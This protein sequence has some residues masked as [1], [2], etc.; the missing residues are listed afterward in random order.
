MYQLVFYVPN[1]H[2]EVVKEAIFKEG[3]GEMEGYDNCCWQTL[4]LGQFRP[5]NSTNPFLGKKGILNKE[6]E[7]R[8][9]C[10]L[11]DEFKEKIV[12]ALKNAHPYEVPAFSL[13][14]LDN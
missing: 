8:V 1:T 3:A 14:K 12:K 6:E 5:G 11:K 7:W 9:E 4:G 10:V 2:L 13:Y